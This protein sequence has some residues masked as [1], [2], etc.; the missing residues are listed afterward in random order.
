MPAIAALMEFTVR[1]DAEFIFPITSNGLAAGPTLRDAVTSAIYE[2]LERDA[3]L[4]T[5]L[6]RLPARVLDA[7]SHP[8]PDVRAL[9]A[10]YRRRGV[11]LALYPAADGSSR[12]GR[13]GSCL[14]G[15]WVRRARRDRRAW[16]KPPALPLPP[17]MPLSR[18]V[19]FVPAFRER[20]RGLDAARV[21]ELVE[22]PSRVDDD[23]GPL[24]ALRRSRAAARVRLPRWRRDLVGRACSA[25]AKASRLDGS[26]DHF[27]AVGQEV[28]YVNLSSPDVEPLGLHT[29]RAVLPGFQPIWFGHQ[30]AQAR[31]STALRDAAPSGLARC[32]LGSA[33][34][35]NPLPTPSWPEHVPRT[36][37]PSPGPSIAARRGGRSTCTTSIAKTGEVA[38]FKEDP[39]ADTIELPA[40]DA[41]RH[42]RSRRPSAAA[43]VADSSATNRWLLTQLGR[44]SSTPDTGCSARSTSGASSA[45]GLSHPAERPLPAGAVRADPAR[46]R[47]VGRRLSLCSYRTCARSRAGRPVAVAV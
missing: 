12:V 24:L 8:D 29:A 33:L 14:P 5:W 43:R 46:E 20:V 25:P 31:R 42:A 34:A 23:G 18:S 27:A 30:R 37:I 3:F 35:L 1:S 4:I 15:G 7:A 13:D 40:T 21:G 11:R 9:V 44:S 47:A 2:V 41:A 45:S 26:L 32:S 17:A 16:R 39:T 28:V 22:D 19:R 36:A 6:N 10:A 38:P